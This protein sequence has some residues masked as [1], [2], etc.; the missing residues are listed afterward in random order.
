MQV[1]AVILLA[2]LLTSWETPSSW[3][4]YLFFSVRFGEQVWWKIL[5]KQTVGLNW[6]H[7]REDVLIY[8]VKYSFAGFLYFN[9]FFLAYVQIW[10]A[11]CYMLMAY[12]Q[13]LR[14]CFTPIA[15][16]FFFYL[17]ETR[18]WLR[19]HVNHSFLVLFWPLNVCVC[20]FIYTHTHIYTYINKYIYA[21]LYLLMYLCRNLS[22]KPVF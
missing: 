12:W 3:H 7:S 17:E 21:Y 5:R 4:K 16:T 8:Q 14:N 18:T 9:F 15:V 13:I 19:I 2:S 22:P 10:I 20:F 11:I 1:G 6:S